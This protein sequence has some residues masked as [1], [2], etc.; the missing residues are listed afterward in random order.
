LV[1]TVADPQ[2]SAAIGMSDEAVR[3]WIGTFGPARAVWIEHAHPLAFVDLHVRNSR[4]V[5][6]APAPP[7]GR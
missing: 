5:P 3:G 6:T 7:S 1:T 4:R 2:P